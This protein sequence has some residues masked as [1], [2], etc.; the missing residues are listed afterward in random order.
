MGNYIE[1]GNGIVLVN[2]LLKIFIQSR[3]EDE[4]DLLPENVR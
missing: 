4:I 2:L 3:E 1:H